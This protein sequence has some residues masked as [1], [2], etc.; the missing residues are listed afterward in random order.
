MTP[1]CKVDVTLPGVRGASGVRDAGGVDE[2]EAISDILADRHQVEGHVGRPP[3]A[4]EE[5]L[6]LRTAGLVGRDQLAVEN[7]IVHIELAGDL[8]H[9]APQSV[10]DIRVP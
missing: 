9:R 10:Q 6:E 1:L 2:Q 7:G 5:V 8:P 3:R 4:P